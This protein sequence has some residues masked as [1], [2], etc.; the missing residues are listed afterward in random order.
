MAHLDP[1][2]RVIVDGLLARFDALSTSEAP[3]RPTFVLLRATPGVG[4]TRLVQE[5]YEALRVRQSPPPFWPSLFRHDIDNSVLAERH[6]IGPR[7]TTH[8]SD[9]DPLATMEYL[10][11][12]IHCED[13]SRDP[14]S[15]AVEE[16]SYLAPALLEAEVRRGRKIMDASGELIDSMSSALG[17]VG[18]AGLAAPAAAALVVPLALPTTIVGGAAA[19]GFLARKIDSWREKKRQSSAQSQ[20][21]ESANDTS[22]IELLA[23]NLAQLSQDLPS[24]L[25]VNDAHYASPRVIELLEHLRQRQTRLLVVLTAWPVDTE[26]QPLLNWWRS[27]VGDEIHLDPLALSTLQALFDEALPGVVPAVRDALIAKMDHNPLTL[28]LALRESARGFRAHVLAART[29]TDITMPIPRDPREAFTLFWSELPDDVQTALAL[30]SHLGPEYFDTIVVDA[31]TN[32]GPLIDGLWDGPVTTAGL[33][34]GERTGVVRRSVDATLHRFIEKTFYDLAATAARDE[35]RI[36]DADTRA[37]RQQLQEFLRDEHPDLSD[38]VLGVLRTRLL[39]LALEC[40]DVEA[41]L[42]LDGAVTTAF[43]L[44]SAGDYTEAL[45]VSDLATRLSARVRLDESEVGLHI[46]AARSSALSSLGRYQEALVIQESVLATYR[47]QFPDDHPD[48]LSAMNNLAAT[49]YFLG[50]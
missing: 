33:D 42:A 8:F 9:H 27:D 35:G 23:A 32:H 30:A 19:V 44:L 13:T 39:E 22:K 15:G 46:R 48:V 4:K 49:Y 41:E 18:F 10:W 45:R 14:L 50:R 47:T 28:R 16:L 40:D 5:L 3:T 24:V 34:G 26:D 7:P 36:S 29:P 25:I 17:I 12:G 43:Q 1:Q 6:L 31:A 2:R 11:W 21:H 20:I 37:V 38:R